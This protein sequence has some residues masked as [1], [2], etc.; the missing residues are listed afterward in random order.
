VSVLHIHQ[1]WQWQQVAHSLDTS[2]LRLNNGY[3]CE[4]KVDVTDLMTLPPCT[5]VN[6]ETSVA[7]VVPLPGYILCD[8]T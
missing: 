4:R 5:Y 1:H 7:M 8:A 3:V 6:P 2:P